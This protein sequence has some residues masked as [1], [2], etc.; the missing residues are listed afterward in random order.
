[1]IDVAD[2]VHP[3]DVVFHEIQKELLHY[4]E[5][6]LRKPT[7]VIANKMDEEGAE[8]GMSLLR[9]STSLPVIPTSAE[10]KQESRGS[11]K[12]LAASV[13]PVGQIIVAFLYFS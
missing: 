8:K 2:T 1:M 6:L 4:D 3:P 11:G 13:Y 9:H 12:N 5:N 10:G 7:V